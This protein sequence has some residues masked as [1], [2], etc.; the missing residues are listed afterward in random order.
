MTSC[1]LGINLGGGRQLI[2]KRT[3]EP[4]KSVRRE[5]FY[6]AWEECDECGSK[7]RVTSYRYSL[8]RRIKPENIEEQVV[9]PTKYYIPVY[10]E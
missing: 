5:K 3:G 2:N 8:D 10:N 7:H 9:P 6:D 1:C 4:A